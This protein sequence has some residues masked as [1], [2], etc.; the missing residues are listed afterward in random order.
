[1]WELT[2]SDG[3]RIP[4]QLTRREREVLERASHGLSNLE[5]GQELGVTIHTVKFHL[6][7]VYKKLEVA[8]RT[9]AAVAYLQD[10][11]FRMVERPEG[12]SET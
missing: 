8:N 2:L 12:G 6:A 9:E 4:E 11:R 7:S 5:I 10:V 3:R 1:V